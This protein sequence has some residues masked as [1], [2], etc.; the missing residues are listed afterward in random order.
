M[1]RIN[2]DSTAAFIGTSAYND[3]YNDEAYVGFMYGQT[4]S[5]DYGTTY[6]NTNKSTI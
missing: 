3:S 5:T 4:G 6:A 1:L 2:N